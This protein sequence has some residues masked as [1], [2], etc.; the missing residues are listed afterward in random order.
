MSQIL[1]AGLIVVSFVFGFYIGRRK[2][3]KPKPKYKFAIGE[4]IRFLSSEDMKMAKKL[5]R[6]GH[7][8][9]LRRDSL[10]R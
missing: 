5:L 8:V 3:K 1:L 10:T 4:K 2:I 7:K 6:R 9:S